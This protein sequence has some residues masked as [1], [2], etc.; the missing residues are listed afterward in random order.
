M[1]IDRD[2][3]KITIKEA[4]TQSRKKIDLM[5]RILGRENLYR[6]L[7]Q[8]PKRWSRRKVK[9]IGS[10]DME[11]L[12]LDFGMSFVTQAVKSLGKEYENIFS[13]DV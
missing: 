1:E 11:Y 13:E 6:A 8:Y 10:R 4:L 7:F 12:R 3:V 5:E 2:L 9:R